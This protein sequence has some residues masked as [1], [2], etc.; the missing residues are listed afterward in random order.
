MAVFFVFI[1]IILYLLLLNTVRAATVYFEFMPGN[2]IA[3]EACFNIPH[4]AGLN[5]LRFATVKANK[6]MM[7][8]FM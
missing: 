4:W 7:M 2:I 8:L 1:G 3:F 6:V 5:F